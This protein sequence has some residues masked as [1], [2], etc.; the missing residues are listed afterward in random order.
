MTLL[1]RG[2]L[3]ST[4]LAATLAAQGQRGGPPRPAPRALPDGPGKEIV[5]RVCGATCHG[6]EIVTG[7]GYTRDNWSNVVNGMV[8]RGAKATSAEFG[9]IVEY[10]GKIF[11]PAPA[12]PA[13]VALAS[14]APAPTTPTSS[15]PRP[16][17][18]ARLSTTPNA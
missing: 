10:L 7:K 14:S 12:P 11:L 15:T 18:A 9:E 16:P 8:A 1:Y 17:N 3:L 2:F 5:Q 4:L 6:V 13:P